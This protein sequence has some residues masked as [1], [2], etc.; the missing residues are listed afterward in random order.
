MEFGLI[1]L[2]G[3]FFLCAVLD[4]IS[5]SVL[6]ATAYIMLTQSKRKG[7]HLLLFLI[8][9]QGAY[10]ILG[11]IFMLGIEPVIDLFQQL[12]KSIF[13]DVIFLIAGVTLIYLSFS[14][15]KL[16][17]SKNDNL[18]ARIFRKLGGALRVKVIVMIAFSVFFI[19]A[20]QAVPYWAT[21]GLITYNQLPILIWLPTIAIYNIVMV[22]PSLVLLL[23]YK[24]KPGKT[25]IK[26][27]AF[28]NRLMHSNATLWAI[29]GAG[30]IFLHLGLNGIIPH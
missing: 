18:Y 9:T 3:I 21:L 2:F 11:V 5:P 19:E 20:T 26:L 8:L 29:G 28:K 25:E 7:Q 22:L 15:P 16:T 23:L 6:G 13:V 27:E 10:F 24:I 12:K 4:T 17:K 14:L 30:G 1:T